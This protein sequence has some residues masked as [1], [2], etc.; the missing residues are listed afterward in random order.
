MITFI[1]DALY[2]L[3]LNPIFGMLNFDEKIFGVEFTSGQYIYSPNSINVIMLFN[4][5]PAMYPVIL[6]TVPIKNIL[7]IKFMYSEKVT[8]I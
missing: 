2:F 3:K 5:Y 7:F 6:K 1:I 4:M 8:K